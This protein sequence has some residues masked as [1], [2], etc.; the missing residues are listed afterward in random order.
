MTRTDSDLDALNNQL[1]E[2]M[3][4]ILRCTV[5][6]PKYGRLLLATPPESRYPYVYPRD[7]SCAVLFLRRVT[8]SEF[9]YDA[10]PE[11]FK[12]IRS[13]AHFTKD[14]MADS[15]YLGQ[16]YSLEGES[17][18]I[19][20]QEDNIAHGISILC[21]YLLCAHALKKEVPDLESFLSCIN[22]SLDYSLREFYHQEIHLFHS[23]TS[24]HES[25]IEEGHT[26]WVNFAFLNAFSLAQETA[27]LMDE[28]NI[29]SR[30]HLRFRRLFLH[31]ISELFV[32]GDR[33]IRRIDPN[34]NIDLRPDFTLLSPFYFGFLQYKPA[35]ERSVAFLEKQLW[36]PELKMIMRY[37]PFYKDFTIHVHA[38]NGPWLQY[39]AILAQFHF[40]NGNIKR[41]NRL[42]GLIDGYRSDSGEIPEHLSTAKRFEDFMRLEWKTGTDFAKEFHKPILLDDVDFDKILEEAN[43]MARS[44][45]RTG[46][47]CVQDDKSNEGGFIRFAM[48]LMWAHVEYSRAL[49]YRAKDWWQTEIPTTWEP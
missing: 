10:A 45:E 43:N 30:S 6:S 16:R 26:C 15:G 12:L 42:L 17:K 18:G 32:E 5:E 24:I 33:Y 41:G 19:Y 46:R 36:D 13:M 44:Y 39:T 28:N 27:R 40:W 21:N 11:A 3:K 35:L 31:S 8:T 9:G 29:I 49:L 20:K 22:R 25:G 38:G 23:T 37:L 7:V 14:A 2:H 34:G 4:I 48:P 47:G 1:T